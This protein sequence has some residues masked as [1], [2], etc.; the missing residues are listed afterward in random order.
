MYG[1]RGVLCLPSLSVTQTIAALLT[2]RLPC[3]FMLLLC[4]HP[5]ST[6]I[7]DA[8]AKKLGLV[9]EVVPPQQLLEASKRLALDIA[10]GAVVYVAAGDE[11][12]CEGSST[13]H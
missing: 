9:D 13:V 7:K 6:P 5:C 10:G 1:S 4:H 12:H 3:P 8:A 11:L 2:E